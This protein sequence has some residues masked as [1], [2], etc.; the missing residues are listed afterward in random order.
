ML[1]YEELRVRVRPCGPARYLI[2]LSG[3]A[4]ALDV[5][6]VDGE[7]AAFRA[8]WDRLVD[9]DLGLAPMGEAHTAEQLRELGRGVYR[10]LFG[11]AGQGSGGGA[12]DCLAAA[13]DL[14]QRMRPARGLRL[15]FDLPPRLRE[16]PLEALCAPPELP[17]QSLAL[18]PGYS[19]VRSLPGGP[20]G[21]RL[22]DPADEPSLIRLLVACASPPGAG[23]ALRADAEV[24]ALRQKLPEVAVRTTVVAGATRER[25]EAALGAHSDLPTAVLLIAHGAY[26]ED[27]GKGVV[28]LETESGGVDRVPADLLS[29]ILIKA[30]LLRLAVLNLCSGAD[31]SSPGARTPS[32]SRGSRRR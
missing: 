20:L 14:A 26:D 1:Q 25:L 6:A 17:Q 21:Q 18:N 31:S 28:L 13:L 19:L 24:A 5:I 27:I 15:R 3:P 4:R 32:R 23:P 7:P 30:P 2:A 9:A 29:G 8:R 10:L 22:P 11:A 16:L 12:G